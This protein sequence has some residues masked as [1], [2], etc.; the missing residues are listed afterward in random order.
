MNDPVR[1]PPT[2]LGSEMPGYKEAYGPY[3]IGRQALQQQFTPAELESLGYT[4]VDP[5]LG[6]APDDPRRRQSDRPKPANVDDTLPGL[7]G[8]LEGALEE[9]D[10]P[11]ARAVLGTGLRTDLDCM[12]FGCDPTGEEPPDVADI[13]A[14]AY[15]TLLDSESGNLEFLPLLAEF[16]NLLQVD[17]HGRTLI[18]YAANPAVIGFL[19]DAGVRID[20][21]DED[22]IPVT[23]FLGPDNAQLIESMY[24]ERAVPAGK[25]RDTAPRL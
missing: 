2:T 1:L 23:E 13:S 10:L 9:R 25:T 11:A 8:M 12:N 17:T 19:L 6:Y 15:A 5:T 22:D 16:G 24:L 14:M 18:A 7:Q 4:L 20:A 3:R 21:I